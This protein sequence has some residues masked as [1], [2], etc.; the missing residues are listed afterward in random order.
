MQAAFISYAVF[1]AVLLVA[2]VVVLI[3]VGVRALLAF[4]RGP[5]GKNKVV[6]GEQPPISDS[7]A[8]SRHNDTAK[9][10]TE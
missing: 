2:V 9:M 4:I 3:I 6:S 5:R 1:L 7:G 8:T 10:S